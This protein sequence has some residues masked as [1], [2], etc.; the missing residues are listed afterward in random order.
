MCA[1]TS[2]YMWLQSEIFASYYCN[3]CISFT[4]CS[5]IIKVLYL[6]VHCSSNHCDVILNLCSLLTSEMIGTMCIVHT[7]HSVAIIKTMLIQYSTVI[8]AKPLRD[9]IWRM[10][11]R[12]DRYLRYDLL[13]VYSPSPPR[14]CNDCSMTVQP[15]SKAVSLWLWQ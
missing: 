6:D 9:F 13:L 3:A 7:Y 1:F 14:H 5:L 8:I 15:V 11:N 4:I 12:P 2:I 10:Q